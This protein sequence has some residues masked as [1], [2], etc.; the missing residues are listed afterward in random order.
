M[1]DIRLQ[2]L[3]LY[4]DAGRCCRPLFIVDL[5][6]QRL[7]IRKDD[8]SKLQERE[9]TG[10]GWNVRR[11]LLLDTCILC[12][13]APAALSG[14]VAFITLRDVTT[15]T[16]LRR[17]CC[18]AFPVAIE[19]TVTLLD[20]VSGIEHVIGMLSRLA[21]AGRESV[22]C[23]K[24]CCLLQELVLKG[25]IEYVDTEEEET[26]MIAMEI[27]D[28]ENARLP[29]RVA[30]S[31]TY[32]H[33]EIHPSMILGVCASIIPFP[34][35]NQSPRNTY[36]SAMGKQAMGTPPADLHPIDP[37]A[38][39]LLGLVKFMQ[40]HISIAPACPLDIF[41]GVMVLNDKQEYFI[42]QSCQGCSN[43]QERVPFNPCNLSL[44]PTLRH[45]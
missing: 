22:T 20:M 39:T 24:A 27:K 6:K 28:L 32:T 31:D 43:R 40:R 34:D 25:A 5:E 3:R 42:V 7:R 14:I 18:R 4:T 45:I 19:V 35:H 12:S 44:P 38:M 1:H 9:T 15:A 36:Q 41:S 10:F 13:L 29:D 30:Y 33:C 37:F 16:L 23:I 26:T 8:I 2:E 21:F 11:F 17:H